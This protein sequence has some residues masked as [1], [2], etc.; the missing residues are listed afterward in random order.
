MEDVNQN[1]NETAQRNIEG[2]ERN[3]VRPATFGERNIAGSE[4]EFPLVEEATESAIEGIPLQDREVPIIIP[5]SQE[6]QEAERFLLEDNARVTTFEQGAQVRQGTNTRSSDEVDRRLRVANLVNPDQII[7]KLA[8]P[9]VIRSGDQTKFFHVA[10]SSASAMN[11]ITKGINIDLRGNFEGGELGRG[12]YVTVGEPIVGYI[13]GN[14]PKYTL[15]FEVTEDMMGI[16]IPSKTT[17]KAKI[18]REL[19]KNESEAS[20][21]VEN[22]FR[23]LVSNETNEFVTNGDSATEIA[24]LRSNRKLHI[25]R[26]KCTYSARNMVFSDQTPAEF[27]KSQWETPRNPKW[28]RKTRQ[29]LSFYENFTHRSWAK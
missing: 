19:G 27:L 10:G 28:D 1:A 25:Q 7:E 6:E 15:E 22:G 24:L 9:S 20:S 14:G 13:A 12:L 29:D 8:W 3:Q 11:I 26:V 4:N 16:A 23:V 2:S 18:Q 5:K 21:I 17:V